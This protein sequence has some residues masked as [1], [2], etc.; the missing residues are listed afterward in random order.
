[1]LEKHG[2]NAAQSISERLRSLAAEVEAARE[3]KDR[4]RFRAARIALET[5]AAKIAVRVLG[6][7]VPTRREP[8]RSSRARGR[9]TKTPLRLEPRG[10]SQP[11]SGSARGCWT[12]WPASTEELL[13]I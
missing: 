10:I 7:T 2:E 8:R 6:P 13:A 11:P 12:R 5:E 4:E 9:S 3:A 1:M